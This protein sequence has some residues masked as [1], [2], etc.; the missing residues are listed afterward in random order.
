MRALL[1]NDG[2]VTAEAGVQQALLCAVDGFKYE[3]KVIFDD[4]HDD[5]VHDDDVDDA[6]DEADDRY[7][8][9]GGDDKC[10]LRHEAAGFI[11]QS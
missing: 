7:K 8:D 2:H 6:D 10:E 9:D 11:V 3:Y 1:D 4:V 5:D